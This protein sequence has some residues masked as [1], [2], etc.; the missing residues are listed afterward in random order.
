[1][2]STMSI[3]SYQNGYDT[4]LT[5]KRGKICF[6]CSV[7]YGAHNMT[8]CTESASSGISLFTSIVIDGMDHGLKYKIYLFCL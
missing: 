3:I 6:S 2:M 4:F 5:K 8:S 1:M 7:R